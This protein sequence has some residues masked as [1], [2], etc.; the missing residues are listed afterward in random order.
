MDMEAEFLNSS[1]VIATTE[2]NSTPAV[3]NLD[4]PGLLFSVVYIF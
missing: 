3:V 4:D 1:D 2:A